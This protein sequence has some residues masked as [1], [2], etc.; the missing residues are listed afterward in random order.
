MSTTIDNRVVE[1]RFD[2]K[3]FEQ[4]ARTSISTLE[5][6]KQSLNLSGAAKGISNITSVAKN[7]AG[8]IKHI[9]DAAT[10]VGHRF[11]VMEIMGI[12]S[13]ANL[14]NSA[15][16][17]GKRMVSALTI[18]PVKTGFS[19]YEL[20]TDSI[21][22][23]LASTK[24]PLEKVNKLL[25]ELN[26]YSDETIYSFSDMT[27][28]IGKFTNAGIEL[29]DAVMAIK[30]ISNE[31]AVSG[32]NA[33]EAS[34]A[35][36]NFSQALSSGYVKLIDWKSI[37]NAN[38]ATKEFKQELI[39]TAVSL[40]TVTKSGDDMYETLSGN[41]FNAVK[42]FNE[43][44]QDEWMT[45][46]VLIETLKRY[47][48]ETTVIGKKAKAAAQ[49]VT[50][51]SQVFDIAKE[52]AQ[53]GWARTW[54]L[55]FGDINQAKA[56]FTPISEFLNGI[57]NG[58]SDARNAIL[59]SALAAPFKGMK[60]ILDK[61]TGSV[62]AVTKA[63]ENL[64]QVVD[65]VIGGKFGTGQERWDALTKAGHNWAEV[66][67][68]VNE[69][70][71]SSVRHTVKLSESQDDLQK[72]QSRTIQQ[73]LEMSDAQ[74]KNLGLTDKEI[75]SLRELER[76]SEKTGIPIE[77]LVKDLDQLSG[78]S[79]LINSFK[80]AGKGLAQVFKAMKGAWTDIFP[81]KTTEE[82]SKALYN[83]I[84]T[85]H[86]FT[87]QF[88]TMMEDTSE[89]STFDKLKRTFK[90]LF[91]LIDI[92]L[93]VVGGPL[94]FA[95][96]GVFKLLGMADVDILGLTASIGDAIVAV[97]DWIDEH[98]I[99]AKGLEKIIPKF[100]DI[101]NAVKQWIDGLK[102]S[103][104]IPRDIV[105]GLVKG[106]KAGVK[107]VGEAAIALGK[108]IVDSIKNFLGIHSPSTEMI[109]IGKNVI[110]GLVKG[111]I[112]GIP[113][114]FRA[115]G[116]LGKVIINA[117]KALFTNFG[118]VSSVV[119]DK[120]KE[121][122]GD[123]ALTIIG[124]GIKTLFNKIASL[125]GQLDLGKLMAAGL[126][127]GI[128]YVIKKFSDVLALFAKPLLGFDKIANAA[129]NMLESLGG[130]FKGLEKSFK[131]DAME[132]KAN[133]L[134]NFAKAILV[135]VVAIAI[136]TTLEPGEVWASI[137][138]I[139][140]L[141]GVL[142]GM[143]FALDKISKASVSMG[144]KGFNIKGLMS[145]LASIG[146]ALLLM[147]A[148][149]KLIG[150]MN[151]DQAKQG[152]IGLAGLIAAV[153]VVFIAFGL[154][155]RGPASANMD[156]A[157]KMLKKMSVALLLM[158]LVVKLAA[159]LDAGEVERGLKVVG[160]I[161]LLFA[162]VIA[163][164]KL[165]GANAS[166]A[167]G[168]LLKM[169]V[170]MLIAVGV[171]KIAAG[172]DN[173]EVN[174]GIKVIK[175]IGVLF[176]AV[177]AISKLAGKNAGKAGWMF[178]SMSIALAIVAGVIHMVSGMDDGEIQK[179]LGVIKTIGILFLAVMAVSSIAGKN[180]AKA[181]GM[182]LAMS[183][184][185]LIMTAVI[186]LLSKMDAKG[187][188]KAVGVIAV[189]EILFIG[190]IGITKFAKD[191]KGTLITIIVAI[192]LM[193]TAIVALSLV[194]E[195][196]LKRSVAALSL[197][198][199][200]FGLIVASTKL[201]KNT[202]QMRTSLLMLTGV[203]ILLAGLV[204]VLSLLD[205]NSVLTNVTALSIL[206]IS[207]SAS[208]VIL[209]RTGR[210]STT[211][212]KNMGAMLGVAAGLALILGL[213]AGFDVE[214]SIQSATAISIL[215]LA[216]S[217]SLNII[218][219][220]SAKAYA[221]VGALA[222]MVIVVGL[223]GL[224]L[225][226]MDELDV[227]PSIETALSLSILL[228]AM[229]AAL[230]ILGAVGAMG[231]AAFIGIGALATLIAGIGGLIVAIGAL[232]TEFPQLEDFL[233]KGI[234]VLE[235]IGHALGSFVGNIIGG[236]IGGVATALPDIGTQLSAF[237]D[238]AQGFIEG[239]KNVTFE[240]VAGA[241][242][243]AAS[244][245]ALTA[246]SFINGL[247]ELMP[248]VP[249]FAELGKK[250][251]S[252]MVEAEDFIAGV[253][254]L[255]EGAVT[256]AKSLAALILAITAANVINGIAEFFNLNVSFADFGAQLESFGTSLVKFS[257]TVKGNIDAEAVQAASDAGLLMAAL[258]KD[259]PRSGSTVVQWF[260][261]EKDLS[262]F[263][264]QLEDF[265][266]SIVKF[267]NSVSNEG[268]GI[269]AAA[270][271]AASDAGLLMSALAQDIPRTGSTVV[272]WFMGE[273]DLAT[274]GDQL[275]DFG[276]SI[277]KFSNSVSNE[278][279]GINIE[280]IEAAKNAGLL[281]S[282]LAQDIPRCGSTVVKWF[283]GEKDLGDFGDRL[284]TFGE[285]LVDFSSS[286]EG[287]VNLDS[288]EA[289]KNAGLLMVELEKALPKKDGIFSKDMNF[290]DFGKGI[291]DFGKHLYSFYKE[292]CL[293]DTF[294]MGNVTEYTDSL[295][296]IVKRCIGLDTS[297]V[298]LFK[299]AINDLSEVKLTEFKEKFS[300]GATEATN[301]VKRIA[302]DLA[303]VK[304]YADKTGVETLRS[305]INIANAL[306][307]DT[308]KEKFGESLT[309][310]VSYMRGLAKGIA[311]LNDDITESTGAVTLKGAITV[312]AN[313]NVSGFTD[314]FSKSVSGAVEQ[315]QG[316]AK[317]I[318]KLVD[319]DSSAAENFSKTIKDLGN[320][321]VSKLIETFEGASDK[322]TTTGSKIVEF[323]VKG[324]K[325]K[326]K[327]IGS[328]LTSGL[329]SA[330]TSAKEYYSNFE[331]A[332]KHLA[333]G[334]ANGIS[335]NAY[336]AAAQA[337]AMALAAKLAAE[338]ALGIQSPS[339]VFY[340]IGG[341]TVQGFVNALSDNRD[342]S[343]VAGAEIAEYARD[344]L[345]KAINKVYD[346]INGNMDMQPTIRPVLDLSSVES[347]VGTLNG[348]FSDGPSVG[349]SANLRA[350]SSMMSDR[351]NGG[352]SDV[353]SAIDKLGKKLSNIGGNTYNSFNGITYDDGS[354]LTEA[355]ETIVRAARVERRR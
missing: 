144:P 175:T 319:V 200:A 193:V 235:K 283:A 128:I 49:D 271:K 52:S 355:V 63:T 88:R 152:F 222:V 59:E 320:S 340:K 351:Q 302:E 289:A 5:K 237:M 145:G 288:V 143:S 155:V 352:N 256:G 126:G 212:A 86:K 51:L 149:V 95:L 197:L 234:P 94:K 184:A 157:G 159:K 163:V 185:L 244:I 286:I 11:S 104:N 246:A 127:G 178:L 10:E 270:I 203:V 180:A 92:I 345:S 339:K 123:D 287:K 280:A 206:L 255:D 135:L 344:G 77:E 209:G 252:F 115:I 130:A 285:G 22:T 298:T 133:A 15:V 226:L 139:T 55:L 177:M 100:K 79:L 191:C 273:K 240:S 260:M 261:G 97:R 9:A 202:K 60:E 84:A 129:S 231:A 142:V 174:R 132:K 219:T 316:L 32:A 161:T 40:G 43:V 279:K 121:I 75:E 346:V 12:T 119:S 315:M 39:D 3:Q 265:G 6:L 46:E 82:R 7:S 58:I 217:V 150:T 158:L 171:V 336:K 348:L 189:L 225:K 89:N 337:R 269:D 137:G 187:V 154:F 114:V 124:S 48:D 338:E 215:L 305:A 221:G 116:E 165:A 247:T 182:L 239:A 275:E 186:F 76:Q 19:E 223:L 224:M 176:L 179:G 236:F 117:A 28:N 211:V 291:T 312:L 304:D 195:Q 259:I 54:E 310:N 35:M 18:D 326:E 228:L 296:S 29:E 317:S 327:S 282:A 307:M 268:K 308:F 4:N 164:S 24:E 156:K 148:T 71:G 103:D 329:G 21:K 264:D 25:N 134:L 65:D 311:G 16:N 205:A 220:V 207:L 141:A 61:A 251:S 218:Q 328:A 238:N 67:N 1:M 44:F 353:V 31:A 266:R 162:G 331:S 42:N 232:M 342:Q 26:Q 281:M 276:K 169:S 8:G 57:I 17:A 216:M 166:K 243:L 341:F 253:N 322:L 292:I 274:F 27:Q 73:V 62:E 278:G 113:N 262:V 210:I 245:A 272:Q 196:G 105:L 131:A 306:P 347:G 334:F 30:G 300:E 85:M 192:G 106:L 112:E 173:G 323:V 257:S 38:M 354:N 109:E 33:N 248:W 70:L 350:I 107:A 249:S 160:M 277:V 91:A 181:G 284:K 37:E 64:G 68:K 90:G 41:A 120:F 183:G 111:I 78:R 190:L 313:A 122:F 93:T 101:I 98:N 325:N 241:G 204:A 335:A 332:G 80:N 138:A 208:M 167:G 13:I 343:Y 333:N 301:R 199:V 110:A 23:I 146:V 324:L 172:L 349:V 258:A 170:A 47:A 297:G 45:S 87:N 314:A 96:K 102:E 66:Q 299:N 318:N 14:T 250:L 242:F 168:M 56:L 140:V 74:L 125:F 118:K 309:A 213:L 34:R 294:K 99:F 53:S 229:S 330:V 72:S 198:M 230:V 194:D 290:D 81:P 227:N 136:L 295:V 188:W 153:S 267:S 147:A 151:P 293:I 201:M 2:N 69:K 233:N 214:P 263:G 50:K 254:T 321:G 303:G 108:S 83:M 20:K 36:Y